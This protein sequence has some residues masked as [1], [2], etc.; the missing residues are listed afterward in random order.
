MKLYSGPVY[1]IDLNMPA[2]ERWATFASVEAPA[3]HALLDDVEE[4]IDTALLPHMN[5]LTRSFMKGIATGGGW[6][7]RQVVN[8]FGEDYTQELACIARHADV[9]VGKLMLGNLIY[10][11]TSLSEMYGCGCS[12]AS[13]EIDG[14]PVLVRNMDWVVPRTTGQYT[15]LINFHKGSH[16]YTSVGVAGMVGVISAMSEHWAVVV[17]QAPIVNKI[18]DW[19]SWLSTPTLLFKWPV[20][21]RIR[22]VCDRIPAYDK[23]ILGLRS[24]YTTVPFFAHVVG[25]QTK[26]HTVVTNTGD[27][28]FLRTKKHSLVQTNHY[29]QG[30]LKEHNPVDD[31]EW[32][33]D[34]YPR[35][36]A[37]KDTLHDALNDKFKR[38]VA[39]HPATALMLLGC[40]TNEDTMQQMLFWPA[41]GHMVVKHQG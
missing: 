30:P 34:T 15:R 2:D 18:S 19:L 38:N 11:F 8:Q 32:E 5:S 9:P 33:W 26:E 16:S 40:V 7:L 14:S 1:D 25:R 13:F 4:E 3:I 21:Q 28:S 35:Y 24:H 17:N 36:D 22:A 41:R 23:L 27:S 29:V 10:D 37:L 12:S 31:D 39:E 6:F 20:L